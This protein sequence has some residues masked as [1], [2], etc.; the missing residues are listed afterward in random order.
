V[1]RDDASFACF[2][3]TVLTPVVV[4]KKNEQHQEK[5][6]ML[7]YKPKAIILDETSIGDGWT[8]QWLKR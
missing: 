3:R 2:L 7:K 8:Y 5:Q 1:V 4:L 6:V